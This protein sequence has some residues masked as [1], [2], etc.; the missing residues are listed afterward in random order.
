MIVVID[1]QASGTTV[2]SMSNTFLNWLLIPYIVVDEYKFFLHFIR[3]R[4]LSL[5]GRAYMSLP[6]NFS[7]HRQCSEVI[8][9]GRIWLSWLARWKRLKDSDH[10]GMCGNNFLFGEDIHGWCVIRSTTSWGRIL[11]YNHITHSCPYLCD[12]WGFKM[13][14]KVRVPS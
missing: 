13:F 3:I 8:E 9:L 5:S 11:G 10:Q 4:G 1:P 6:P 2:Q 12:W 14:P 7:Q